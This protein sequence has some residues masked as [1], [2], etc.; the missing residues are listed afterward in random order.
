[1]SRYILRRLFQVI[2]TMWGVFTVLFILTF[3]MP[4]D[5]LRVVLGEDYRRLDPRV[6]EA[7]R[8]EL[9]LDDPFILQ[10]ARFLWRAARLDFGYS[11]IHD[12]S[13]NEIIGYRVPRTLQLMSGGLFVAV[14]IGV[15]A[16]IAAAQKQYSWIDHSLT[17][18]SLLIVSVPVFVL[19][20]VMQLFLTQEDFGIALFPVAGYEEGSFMHMILPSLVL[21]LTLSATLARVTRASMLEVR[22]Q[23]YITTA[24]AKGLQ[25]SSVIMR[26]QFRN[27]LIPIIT[28]V[29]QDVGYLLGGSLVT[30]T[31]FNWP[32]L[33]RAVVPAIQRH[34]TPV[35]LGILLF[36]S[37]L[38]ILI[39]LLTDIIYA[40]VDPRI[41]YVGSK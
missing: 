33:G 6:I 9:G 21:G 18:C 40:V 41:Q 38:F 24:H 23:A 36:G 4:G 3:L 30:E 35:V 10:Y 7:T 5:P 26:H 22:Q 28:I 16:G 25:K 11:Y 1:L 34:D 14:V 13:V 2:P 17:T 8:L 39:N 29:A 12:Q 20:L 19:A 32:G 15:S 37:L 31:I 27:A